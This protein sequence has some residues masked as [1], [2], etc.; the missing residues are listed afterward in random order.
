[1]NETYQSWRESALAGTY[2][3]LS[4]EWIQEAFDCSLRYGSANCWTG[5]SG[6][7]A[8]YVRGLLRERE[9]MLIEIERINRS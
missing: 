2:T 6:N 4:P 1:M 8:A 5:T 9:H 3:P 7:L